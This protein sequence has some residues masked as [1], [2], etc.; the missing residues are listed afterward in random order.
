MDSLFSRGEM[1]NK[2]LTAVYYYNK[3]ILDIAEEA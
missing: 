1:K 3:N 2:K